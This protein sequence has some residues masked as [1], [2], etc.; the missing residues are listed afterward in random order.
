MMGRSSERPLIATKMEEI[1]ISKTSAGVKVYDPK[2]NTAMMP[3]CGEDLVAFHAYQVGIAKGD[4]KRAQQLLH[5]TLQNG[6]PI[7]KLKSAATEKGA[8]A[9]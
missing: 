6:K 4:G 3:E 2:T 1:Q 9:R 5:E 8:L 7:T